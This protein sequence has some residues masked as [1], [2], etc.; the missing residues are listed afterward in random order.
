MGKILYITNCAGGGMSSWESCKNR[1]STWAHNARKDQNIGCPKTVNHNLTHFL[2]EEGHDVSVYIHE[3]GELSERQA[4]AMMKIYFHKDAKA[5]KNKELDLW[6]KML[7][8]QNNRTEEMFPWVSLLI[9]KKLSEVARFQDFDIVLYDSCAEFMCLDKKQWWTVFNNCSILKSGIPAVIK[10]TLSIEKIFSWI[11]SP[12]HTPETKCLGRKKPLW[13]PEYIEDLK[14]ILSGIK[15]LYAI[16]DIAPLIGLDLLSAKG[17]KGV[18]KTIDAF[19]TKTEC[20]KYRFH[21]NQF[22]PIDKFDS[23][24][25]IKNAR[26]LKKINK[27][28]LFDGFETLML[29]CTEPMPHLNIWERTIPFK[30]KLNSD[31]FTDYHCGVTRITDKGYKEQAENITKMLLSQ[32][33]V[34]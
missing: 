33:F 34:S 11:D 6:T 21:A 14:G 23:L 4:K 28:E 8:Y 16:Q 24:P 2:V 10:D 29:Q 12:A 17:R 7:H 22:I 27:S 1:T 25:Q 20:G 13:P 18:E 30:E 3:A 5:H 31:N 32:T 19:F 15:N 26:K 9:I